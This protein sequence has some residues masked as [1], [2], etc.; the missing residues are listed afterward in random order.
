ML[1]TISNAAEKFGQ[2]NARGIAAGY[3]GDEQI[4]SDARVLFA[5]NFELGDLKQWDEPRGSIAISN[6]APH[7]G[8]YC[9][10]APMQRGEN[11][12]GDAIKWFMPGADKVYVRFYVKFSIDYQYNH[13]FVWLGAT[14]A[15]NKWSA[16]GKAGNKP[17][18]TY[19]STGM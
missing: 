3:P 14:Q 12:G 17:D 7:A 16:F 2:E 15:N 11:Q 10:Y 18:G 8:K 19:Y 13:H 6:E 5:D 4:A 9:A 1:S